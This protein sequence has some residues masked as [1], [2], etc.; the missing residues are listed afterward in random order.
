MS[1]PELLRLLSPLPP[2]L[3]TGRLRGSRKDLPAKNPYHQ[4]LRPRLLCQTA[5]TTTT[6]TETR[7]I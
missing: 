4:D 7:K 6:L 2:T 3:H 1:M 5:T